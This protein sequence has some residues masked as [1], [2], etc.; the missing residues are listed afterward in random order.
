MSGHQKNIK[1]KLYSLGVSNEAQLY[2]LKYDASETDN[3]AMKYP[4]KVKAM[5]IILNLIK[6]DPNTQKK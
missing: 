1:P 2:N 3:L 6:K 4:E 5:G